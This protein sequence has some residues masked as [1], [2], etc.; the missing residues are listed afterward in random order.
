MAASGRCCHENLHNPTLHRSLHRSTVEVHNPYNR[1][2]SILRKAQAGH[3][4]LHL[5]HVAH[6]MQVQV[7]YHLRRD[8]RLQ[9]NQEMWINTLSTLSSRSS[10]L[11]TTNIAMSQHHRTRTSACHRQVNR[12]NMTKT[13]LTKHLP[14]MMDLACPVTEWKRVIQNVR[15]HPTLSRYLTIEVANRM[16]DRV[17]LLLV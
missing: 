10:I 9:D 12:L 8:L 17:K 16:V 5:T 2:Q 6:S 14:H 7:R 13:Y 1:H 4:T 15:D 11:P 3:S